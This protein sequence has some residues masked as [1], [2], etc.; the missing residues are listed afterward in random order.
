ME[1]ALNKKWFL[2]PTFVD[3]TLENGPHV[4][5]IAIRKRS[6]EYDKLQRQCGLYFCAPKPEITNCAKMSCQAQTGAKE[7]NSFQSGLNQYV[8]I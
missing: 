4:G 3:E 1:Q 7:A 5:T 6:S 8:T 2:S